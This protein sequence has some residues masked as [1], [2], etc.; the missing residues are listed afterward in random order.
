MWK[1]QE[2]IDEIVGRHHQENYI[3]RLQLTESEPS[4]DSDSLSFLWGVGGN[5]DV[6]DGAHVT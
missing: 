4:I 5:C 3:L 6:V 1:G 2:V